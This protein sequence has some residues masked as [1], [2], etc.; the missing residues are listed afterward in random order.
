MFGFR[1]FTVFVKPEYFFLLHKKQYERGIC[2][3]ARGRDQKRHE[4]IPGEPDPGLSLE[5]RRASQPEKHWKTC[6]DCSSLSKYSLSLK[7]IQ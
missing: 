3:R 1:T 7:W 6:F 4:R 2:M 5:E